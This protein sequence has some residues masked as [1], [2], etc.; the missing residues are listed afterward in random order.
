MSNIKTQ[1]TTVELHTEWDKV[2]NRLCTQFFKTNC[3]TEFEIV[4]N[5]LEDKTYSTKDGEVK[6]VKG[7]LKVLRALQRIGA[8]KYE[9]T[10]EKEVITDDGRQ[11]YVYNFK[12]SEFDAKARTVSKKTNKEYNVFFKQLGCWLLANK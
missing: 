6:T 10:G 1:K 2:Y 4:L 12:I 11:Y 9:I 8:L 3:S 7:E 5:N